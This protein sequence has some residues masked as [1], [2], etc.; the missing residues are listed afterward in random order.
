MTRRS[1]ILVD[2]LLV[3]IF[4]IG[5]IKLFYEVRTI[6]FIQQYL[7]TAAMLLQVYV[8]AYILHK[9]HLPLAI[10][11]F[12]TKQWQTSVKWWLTASLLILT[13]SILGHHLWQTYNHRQLRTS[14]HAH[15]QFPRWL[16]G[17]P[18]RPPLKNEVQIFVPHRRPTLT[19]RWDR[20]ID[21]EL[22]SDGEIRVVGGGQWVQGYA[23]GPHIKFSGALKG[24]PLR[25]QVDGSRL[26]IQLT[27]AGKAIPL[28][29][30]RG[31]PQ[32]TKLTQR[33]LFKDLGWLWH[34]LLIQVLMVA[35]PEEFF[36]RGYLQTRLEA[37]WPSSYVRGLP[38]S[39]ANLVVSILFAF[40]HFLI[41]HQVYRLGVFFPS[42]L[43]GMMR[44]KTGSLLAPVLFHATANILMKLLEV[45]YH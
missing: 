12:H 24:E 37:L 23:I 33:T 30:V 36:Y 32:R 40:T 15:L 26:T 27:R 2:V 9:R 22:V 19:I 10:V 13:P 28:K 17:K 25:V 4:T 43:F 7:W 41:G 35:L 11:G 42:L 20:P 3:Y 18:H 34:L 1:R 14:S 16:K 29:N 31:G 6:S 21:G 8:P 44:Q 38:I 5:L 39:Y 45:W